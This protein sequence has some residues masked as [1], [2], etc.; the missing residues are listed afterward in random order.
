MSQ[1]AQAVDPIA[2]IQAILAAERQPEPKEPVKEPEVVETPEAQPEKEAPP[3][4]N[5]QVEGKE[6]KE[7][8]PKPLEI[9]EDQLEALELEVKEWTKDGKRN[10]SKRTIKE[11]R[12]GYMRLDDYSRNI[13]EVARQ[14][15]EV[16]EKIR[17][18]IESEKKVYTDNL[19]L[20]SQVVLQTAAHELKDVN[21]NDLAANDPAKYV[22]LRNRADQLNN[23]YASIKAKQSEIEAKAKDEQSKALKKAAQEARTKLET[24][25]PTWN[26]DLY[27][28]VM[29][30]GEKFGFKTEE[31]AE[32]TDARALKLLHAVL[33]YEKLKPGNP[34]TKKVVV[35]PKVVKPGAASP[36]TAAQAKAAEAFKRLQGSGNIEDAAAVIRSRM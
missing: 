27:K 31:V 17:Q 36:Q 10:L 13:Q 16:P 30:A 14:R 20:L 33:E 15:D 7:D 3:E 19:Q 18:A 1:A 4:T 9:P 21:W 8:A 34:E 12:E 11:L 32:W 23:A 5:T 28:Q 29:K 22:Q 25:I 35:A 6:V 2:K 24:D 26:D